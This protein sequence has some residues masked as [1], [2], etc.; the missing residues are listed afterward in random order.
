V[1]DPVDGFLEAYAAEVQTVARAARVLVRKL[2]PEAEEKLHRP[3]KVIAYGTRRKFC[4]IAPH[5]AWVNL[6]FHAGASLPDPS[7]L[8]EGRGSSMRHVKLAAPKDVK[9]AALAKLI[10]AAAEGAS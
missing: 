4:A 1:A 6:Q 5:K 7:G 2:V 9:R 8:L 10:R 3:W